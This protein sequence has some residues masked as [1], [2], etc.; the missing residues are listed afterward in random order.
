MDSSQR[1][2][3]TGAG[4]GLGRA[5][6]FR[7]AEAGWRVAC[8]D[9]KLARAEET[10][11]LITGFGIGA[12][13]LEVDVGSD[14]SFEALRDMVLAAWDGVDLVIN[15]AGVSGGGS[16]LNTSM[17]DWQWMLNINLLGVVRGC[18]LFGPIMV[19]Q[20]AGHIVNIASFAALAG[21]PGMATYAT[22]KAGVV[23]VSE[24]LR[25]DL[26]GSG[27]GVSVV[28][29]SFFQTNLLGGFRAP[30]KTSLN[31]ATALMSSAKETASDIAEAIY[32][33]VERGEFL[34]LPSALVR[35]SWRLKRWFPELYFR[36]LM[37]MV[38]TRGAS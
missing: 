18:R 14:D 29:P 26:D 34:I 19:E 30:D 3:I 28:C 36:K 37:Q 8:A 38:R 1:V 15:N 31:M 13:A 21:G 17:S 5:L 12:M 4:S 9:I 27:I 10:V 7:Y 24:G 35:K 22:A 6:A 11:S 2:L 33:G 23:T 25:A 16:V 20:G 32:K